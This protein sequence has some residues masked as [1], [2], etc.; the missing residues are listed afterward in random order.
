MGSWGG[1]EAQRLTRLTLATYGTTC[2]LRWDHE[3]TLV[4]TTADHVVP[5]SHGGGHE[6]EN[7][8]PACAHCNSARGNRPLDARP[9]RV[10]RV[11]GLAFFQTEATEATRQPVHFSPTLKQI[12]DS[13]QAKPDGL[14]WF[15]TT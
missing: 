14:A 4:A 10:E 12:S 5:R 9:R 6:L 13:D 3:C 2:W 15:T 8:R 1:R 7:L 11:D